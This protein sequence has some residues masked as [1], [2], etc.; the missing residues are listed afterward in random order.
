MSHNPAIWETEPMEDVGLDIYYAASPTYPIKLGRYRHDG[1]DLDP[2]GA[3]WYDYLDRGEEVVRVGSFV[4]VDTSN[5]G[6]VNTPTVCKVQDDIIWLTESNAAGSSFVDAANNS[7]Q[8]NSG[9]IIRVTWRG[10]GTYYGVG[11]DEEHIDLEIVEAISFVSYRVKPLIHNNP[12][13]LGYYNCWSYGTG[14]ETN[15][16]RDDYNAVTIDKGVKASMPLA[17]PYEEERR[18]SGLIFSGI[19]NST[20]GVNDTNQFIQ[21]EPITKDLNPINGSIQ[22]LFAR[23]TDLVTFCEN[24]VFKI[25]AK[26]DALFNADGNTNITSNAAVL[27][28]A[29]PFSGEYGISKNPESFASE[30]Y[31]LYFTDKDR[32]AVLRLSRD[33]ITP[34]S[35]A[36]MKDWFRDHTRFATSLI[37]SFDNRDDHYN[38]TLDTL[39]ITTREKEAYTVS[40]TEKKRGWESF[41]SFIQQDG[42]NSKNIYYTFPNNYWIR[43]NLT[44]PWGEPYSANPDLSAETWQH[45]IDTD[46]EFSNTAVV[47]GSA[48]IPI[49]TGAC[50]LLRVGMYIE[51]NGIPIDTFVISIDSSCAHVTLSEAVHVSDGTILKATTS[52][53][54]FY[55]LQHYSMVTTLFNG[56]KGTVKRFKT[57]D[58]EGTQAKTILMEASADVDTLNYLIE[59]V[60]VGQ[61]YYDN[62]AKHGW[63]V[64]DIF[65]DIQEGRVPEFKSKENKWFNNIIGIENIDIEDSLDTAEF[66][67]QGLGFAT[68]LGVPTAPVPGCT[69]PLYVEYDAS[70]TVDDGSCLTLLPIIIVG[71]TDPTALNYNANV[72]QDD[73]S[74]IYCAVNNNQAIEQAPQGYVN[75]TTGATSDYHLIVTGLGGDPNLVAQGDG[76][77]GYKMVWSRANYNGVI[78]TDDD[79][80]SQGF[81]YGANDFDLVSSGLCAGGACPD[82]LYLVTV[83]DSLGCIYQ[84]SFNVIYGC[85]DPTATNYNTTDGIPTVHEYTADPCQY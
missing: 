22:K 39:N 3:N 67:L 29:M 41:K 28:Q 79:I 42:V 20:S 76:Y 78:Y 34:I 23:D 2:L 36:G 63:Y 11:F 24:K 18:A 60:N 80:N 65:T 72:T 68:G 54:N 37:G 21:A 53:N 58:Y 44:D 19:Y 52:R 45:A 73:G 5:A 56:D 55:G 30:S 81:G 17:T 31:R 85:T 14:V 83:T 4:F 33:G 49:T 1:G 66:S 15:R 57:L 25:L 13:Q 48:N 46:I 16:I 6:A 74:C 12:I 70:A 7:I 43:K 32:G 8:L 50:Q 35:D 59:G 64:E 77:S 47:T 40:Y 38:L 84:S 51:G 10:E 27:G 61:I 9:D 71:C 26:K 62:Y 69:D 75:P 82:D